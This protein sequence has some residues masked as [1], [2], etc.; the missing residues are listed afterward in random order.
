MVWF[1]FVNLLEQ[2][3]P[4]VTLLTILMAGVIGD[5]EGIVSGGPNDCF[6]TD[7]YSSCFND[8][9]YPES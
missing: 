5:S 7:K 3:L 1:S 9:V 6:T 4:I 8:D 2:L